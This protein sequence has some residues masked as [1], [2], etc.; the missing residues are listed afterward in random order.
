[1]V[2]INQR[3]AG[4]MSKTSLLFSIVVGIL[5]GG[6]GDDSSPPAFSQVVA[7]GDSYSDAGNAN[8]SQ[9]I[10][11]S[12]LQPI[13]PVA[14]DASLT[15]V[16]TPD[17]T[18]YWQGHW[19]NGVTAV[20]NLAT[21]LNVPLVDYAVG[22]A[23]SDAGNYYAWMDPYISTGVLGQIDRFKGALASNSADA[24]ALYVVFISANDLFQH[25]DSNIVDSSSTPLT[26]AAVQAL[27]DQSVANIETA[28]QKLKNL[29]AMHVMVVGSSDLGLLPWAN[30]KNYQ[31]LAVE[32][33]SF[34]SEASTFRDRINSRLSA[35]L[36]PIA[37][38][39]GIQIHYFDHTA[40]STRIRSNAA[41][42]GYLNIVDACQP[43]GATGNFT[44]ACANP[45]SYYFWDEY[46][47]TRRTHKLIADEMLATLAR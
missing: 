29:G 20:E 40:A 36:A 5:L 16:E 3:R 6:C 33:V 35:E 10:S 1:M 14:V 47:P 32:P 24:N 13:G 44:A 42:N 19:S 25:V 2:N 34:V 11:K 8:G 22:G 28:V 43:G 9:A 4:S 23:K 12:L 17:E 46:H 7:F 31:S 37:R 30:W 18:H 26:T 41:A 38:N 45:D 21:L 27:A 39:L 15:Q